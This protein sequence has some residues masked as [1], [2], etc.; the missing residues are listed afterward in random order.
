MER[1]TYTLLLLLRLGDSGHTWL[2]THSWPSP[3]AQLYARAAVC[4]LS[5]LF[6]EEFSK[7]HLAESG[8]E[9]IKSRALC[10]ERA[11][12]AQSLA[13]WTQQPRGEWRAGGMLKW[14][15]GN[16]APTPEQKVGD[17]KAKKPLTWHAQ[18][19]AF[20]KDIFLSVTSVESLSS[21]IF[22]CSILLVSLNA[23]P[24]LISFALIFTKYLFILN[25]KDPNHFRVLATY[26]QW[27]FWGLFSKALK[28]LN[29]IEMSWH[30]SPNLRRQEYMVRHGGKRCYNKACM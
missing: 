4:A 1:S 13:S 7:S 8:A 29:C 26:Y 24:V 21:T 30:S 23:Y 16:V 15:S 10:R 14:E 18:P 27:L 17:S 22:H 28:C 6:M 11:S 25:K 9:R 3:R 12:C 19:P 5:P 20:C 2:Q